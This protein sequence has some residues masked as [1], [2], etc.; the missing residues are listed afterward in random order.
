MPAM[1]V[2]IMSDVH[3]NSIAMARAVEELS[4]T[5][6]EILLASRLGAILDPAADRLQATG[7][8]PGGVGTEPLAQAS[9]LGGGDTSKVAKP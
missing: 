4:A 3:C 2:G 6:D 1:L 9:P 8:E 5:V 7:I